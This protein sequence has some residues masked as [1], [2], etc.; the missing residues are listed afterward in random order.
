[1]TLVALAAVY[2]H[3]SDLVA[4]PKAIISTVDGQGSVEW[5]CSEWNALSDFLCTFADVVTWNGG[6]WLHLINPAVAHTQI[7]LFALF[8]ARRKD[9]FLRAQ[10][11]QHSLTLPADRFPINIRSFC[12]TPK[13]SALNDAQCVYRLHKLGCEDTRLVWRQL[14]GRL[15]CWFE[16]SFSTT[17]DCVVEQPAESWIT[18]PLHVQRPPSPNQASTNA[19][20]PMQPAATTAA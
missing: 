4:P 14:N 10:R 1:M 15:R 6:R 20:N 5:P 17:L 11:P 12:A 7:D 18:H 2:E 13:D 19:T 16:P 3:P 8:V 9:L